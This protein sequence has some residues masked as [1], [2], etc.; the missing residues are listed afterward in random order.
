MKQL[1]QKDFKGQPPHVRSAIVVSNG[2]AYG[3]EVT[4]E[5]VKNKGVDWALKNQIVSVLSGVYD[6]TDWQNSAIDREVTA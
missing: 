6:A 3:L 5:V 4:A 1:T 2:M